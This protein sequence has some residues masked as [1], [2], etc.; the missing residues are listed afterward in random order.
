M[1]AWGKFCARIV[2]IDVGLFTS[3]GIA[4]IIPELNVTIRNECCANPPISE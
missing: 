2:G 3:C 1:D 4:A